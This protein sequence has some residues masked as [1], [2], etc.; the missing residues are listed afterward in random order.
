MSSSPPT[1]RPTAAFAR[2]EYLYNGRLRGRDCAEL[3]LLGPGDELSMVAKA[4]PRTWLR[5]NGIRSMKSS[6]ME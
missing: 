6:T 3:V 2:E 1:D 5:S 4:R